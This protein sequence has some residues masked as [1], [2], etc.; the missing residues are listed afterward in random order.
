MREA[1]ET[2]LKELLAAENDP[3]LASYLAGGG[4]CS[5]GSAEEL[6]SDT[7]FRAGIVLT[8]AEETEILGRLTPA[9][10]GL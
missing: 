1:A 6:M 4:P 3:D 7:A 2:V 10:W 9:I 8:E 5:G